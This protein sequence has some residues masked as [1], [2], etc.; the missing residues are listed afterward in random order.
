MARVM[1]K[2]KDYALTTLRWSLAVFVNTLLNLI[3]AIAVGQLIF[4]RTDAFFQ[5]YSIDAICLYLV[6]TATAQSIYP[7]IT[8]FGSAVTAG[9]MAESLPFLN[10]IAILIKRGYLRRHELDEG[11]YEDM[12]PTLLVSMSI[13]TLTISLF[14]FLLVALNLE[15]FVRK[16]PKY[17]LLGAMGGIGSF[18]LKTSVEQAKYHFWISLSG[19][20]PALSVLLAKKKYQSPF[21]VPLTLISLMTSFYLTASILGYNMSEL[22]DADWLMPGPSSNIAPLRIFKNWSLRLVD[23]SLV[24]D[25]IP[26][27]IGSAI[28][29]MLHLPINAPSFARSSQQS[30]SMNRELIANGVINLVTSISGLLPSY[31]IYTASVLFIQAGA[32]HKICSLILAISTGSALWFAIPFIR[33]IPTPAVLLL[34]FYLGLELL[35]ESVVDG[36]K[37]TTYREYGIIIAMILSMMLIGFTQG[38]LI[39][40]LL[41]TI[42][43]GY[44]V[45]RLDVYNT[46]PDPVSI[47]SGWKSTNVYAPSEMAFLD[48]MRP[49]IFTARLLG[50]YHFGNAEDV[51]SIIRS[52]IVAEHRY[53]ILDMAKVV[54]VDL[55]MIEGI[56]ELI[57]EF[58]DIN[59]FTVVSG[60]SR[61]M[62]LEQLCKGRLKIV[63]TLPDGVAWIS[64]LQLLEL[65][66]DISLKEDNPNASSIVSIECGLSR[67]E[68]L[69]M[70]RLERARYAYQRVTEE[71]KRVIDILDSPI[72]LD[73]KHGDSLWREGKTYAEACIVQTGEFEEFN[74]A[75]LQ[76]IRRYHRGAWMMVREAIESTPMT[77]SCYA[78]KNA[79]VRSIPAYIIQAAPHSSLSH[80]LGDELEQ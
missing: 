48:I 63:P 57:M 60:C 10:T 69:R 26:V 55:N 23:W 78:A 68:T 31:F 53:V 4:P 34:L 62:K 35:K 42:T 9:M 46:T 3:D 6:C 19:F 66:Q 52:N 12:M 67:Q 43:T 77:T 39:G 74:P 16:C 37:I 17:V 2:A 25:A 51:L 47:D 76:P 58:M 7:L 24:G 44:D 1:A 15:R 22:R 61:L 21:L 38:L 71:E 65:Q 56:E 14:F 49:E 11:S 5:Q 27:I 79:S 50:Y 29:A 8:S 13:H 41:A 45:T 75:S 64:R 40:F 30:F 59:S 72:V 80:L 70:H 33:F 18:L 28:F 36:W 32:D 54:R 73:L 20:I